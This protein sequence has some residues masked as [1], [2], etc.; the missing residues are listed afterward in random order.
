M[1]NGARLPAAEDKLPASLSHAVKALGEGIVSSDASTVY[2][3]PHQYSKYSVAILKY[4]HCDVR[5]LGS[6][7]V[8]SRFSQYAVIQRLLRC[9]SSLTS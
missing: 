5:S 8:P 6:I 7:V 1:G 9:V 4:R 3:R 2:R